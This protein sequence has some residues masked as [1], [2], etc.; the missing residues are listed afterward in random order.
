[1]DVAGSAGEQ[2]IQDEVTIPN[3]FLDL[4]SARMWKIFL[5]SGK[6][7]SGTVAVRSLTTMASL[8]ALTNPGVYESFVSA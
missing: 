6:I 7:Y 5:L 8:S 4:I 2:T 3:T 1:M